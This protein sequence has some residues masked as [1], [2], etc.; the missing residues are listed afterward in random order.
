MSIICFQSYASAFGRGG[1][2]IYLLYW[3]SYALA[4][5][6]GWKYIYIQKKLSY[7]S[8]ESTFIFNINC[9]TPRPSALLHNLTIRRDHPSA[10][11][12]GGWP[13]GRQDY[14]FAIDIIGIRLL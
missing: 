6:F 12:A 7:A 1:K 5:G 8:A 2:Y 11:V 3:L 9:I 13:S 4:F 10:S 14:A